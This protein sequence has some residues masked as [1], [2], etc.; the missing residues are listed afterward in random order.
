MEILA[1]ICQILVALGA[2]AATSSALY[3]GHKSSRQ[4]SQQIQIQSDREAALLAKDLIRQLFLVREEALNHTQS[5][6]STEPQDL[7][8]EIFAN[9][10]LLETYGW[11]KPPL[12]PMEDSSY[13]ED[14]EYEIK[15]INQFIMCKAKRL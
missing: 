13:A 3:F 12:A 9:E 2:L 6:G 7:K 5:V 4:Y 15:S 8:A 10:Q 14:L 1:M 11:K